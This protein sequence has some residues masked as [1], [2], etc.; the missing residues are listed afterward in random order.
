MCFTHTIGG[1][2]NLIQLRGKG[3]P[4]RLSSGRQESIQGI[5][6]FTCARDSI[7]Y[8]KVKKYS[9][10]L[11]VLASELIPGNWQSARR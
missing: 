9:S 2:S 5:N 10:R 6:V 11:R 1:G 4:P 7:Q 8:T 3:G